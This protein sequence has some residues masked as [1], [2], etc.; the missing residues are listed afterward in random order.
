MNYVNS[1]TTLGLIMSLTATHLETQPYRQHIESNR[2][3]LR[4]WNPSHLLKDLH[5][6]LFTH[7]ITILT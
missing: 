3:T 1:R 6:E 4:P 5:H 2:H 7:D